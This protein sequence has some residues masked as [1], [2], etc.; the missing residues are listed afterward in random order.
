M[1]FFSFNQEFFE[2]NYPIKDFAKDIF[3]E[4]FNKHKILAHDPYGY[5]G[6][7]KDHKS[8]RGKSLEKFNSHNI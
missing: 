6:L 8:I 5:H 3:I 4:K 7:E 2:L 1:Y